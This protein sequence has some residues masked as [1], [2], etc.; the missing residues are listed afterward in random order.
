MNIKAEKA[1]KD[2]ALLIQEINVNNITILEEHFSEEDSKK[3]RDR[4][5][6]G[7]IAKEVP[8][9]YQNIL[10]AKPAKKCFERDIELFK[11]QVRDKYGKKIKIDDVVYKSISEAVE[12]LGIDR[13]HLRAKLNSNKFPS[14]QRL[15]D[16]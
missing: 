6:K 13:N 10:K 11:N 16:G 3:I 15:S 14:Y 2:L 5:L 8:Q 1:H 4:F 9:H 12:L 7:I